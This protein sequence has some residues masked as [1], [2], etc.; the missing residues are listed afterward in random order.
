L[1]NVNILIVDQPKNKEMGVKIV[2]NCLM[3]EEAFI[4]KFKAEGVFLAEG[5]QMLRTVVQ[6]VQGKGRP[7][8]E[9]VFESLHQ[10]EEEMTQ[11]DRE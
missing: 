8:K 7:L 1:S 2:H 5:R 3:E 11:E 4:F 9:L 10:Q 6:R